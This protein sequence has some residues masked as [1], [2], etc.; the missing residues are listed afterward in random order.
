M[1]SLVLRTDK[2][3]HCA[4]LCDKYLNITQSGVPLLLK[5]F[6]SKWTALFHGHFPLGTQLRAGAQR[7]GVDAQ[8]LIDLVTVK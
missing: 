5:H 6:L 7:L 1:L 8:S 4:H 3:D 2:N